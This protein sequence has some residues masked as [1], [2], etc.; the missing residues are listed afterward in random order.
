MNEKNID[1]II[2]SLKVSFVS[3]RIL[4]MKEFGKGLNT[5]NIMDIIAE[6]PTLL[7]GIFV[8]SNE[9][10]PDANYLYRQSNPKHS[11]C[12]PIVG[13]CGRELN[14][15]VAHV[16]SDEKFCEIVTTAYCK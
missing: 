10:K 12:F 14:I 4:Y 1:D 15:P 11:L 7:Q 8:T 5:Y 6:C 16:A 3:K 2:S 9:S 13:A